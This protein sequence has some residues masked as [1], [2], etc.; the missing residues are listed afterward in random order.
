MTAQLESRILDFG[1]NEL[2]TLATHIVICAAEPTV[3]SLA[4]IGAANSLG[5][6]AFGAGGA[7]S[8]P[9]DHSVNG[10]F[11]ASTNITDG[12]IVTTGTA[13]WW[14]VIDS[15]NARLHAHQS[16]SATQAVTSGN[17]FTLSSFTIRIPSQ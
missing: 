5:N 7:F 2:D 13:A 6:K 3:Y 1:L 16:L 9:S 10:R 4:S 17:T 15:P 11:V 14:A 8:V 12:T